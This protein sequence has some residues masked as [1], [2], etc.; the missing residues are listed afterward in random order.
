MCF[1][2]FAPVVAAGLLLALAA[3][4]EA[5]QGRIL[6][7]EKGTYLGQTATALPAAQRDELNARVKRRS[8]VRP[9]ITPSTCNMH[10]HRC[11]RHA[12]KVKSVTHLPRFRPACPLRLATGRYSM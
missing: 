1:R 9:N 12:P 4:D 5:E 11:I 3:R 2:K 7:Y 8:G 10:G 6:H